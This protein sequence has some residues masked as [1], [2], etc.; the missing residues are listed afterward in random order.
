MFNINLTFGVDSEKPLL[1]MTIDERKFYV[2]L[3]LMEQGINEMVNKLKTPDYFRIIYLEI[4]KNFC[5]INEKCIDIEEILDNIDSYMDGN[6]D[7]SMFI[8][9]E[10]EEGLL[11]YIE[12]HEQEIISCGYFDDKELIHYQWY[13]NDKFEPQ[14]VLDDTFNDLLTHVFMG[15]LNYNPSEHYFRDY[16]ENDIFKNI[17][18]K[19]ESMFENKNVKILLV[20]KDVPYVNETEKSKEIL[21]KKINSDS[22][23]KNK[24]GKWYTIDYKEFIN[25]LNKVYFFVDSKPIIEN[26]LL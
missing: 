3:K 7:I 19:S 5:E 17:I 10:I 16:I 20:N 22:D 8:N 24:E 12:M 6:Q 21:V 11:D 4:I 1:D 26:K 15:I 25:N 14:F 18:L 9:R 23:D 13:D 2:L